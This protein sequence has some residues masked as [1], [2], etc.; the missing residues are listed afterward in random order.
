LHKWGL[1]QNSSY[2][3][4]RADGFRRIFGGTIFFGTSEAMAQAE[5]WDCGRLRFFERMRL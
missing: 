5:V 2:C 3:R 4:R 1:P